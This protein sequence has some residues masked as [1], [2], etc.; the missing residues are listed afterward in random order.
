MGI[1]ASE[2]GCESSGHPKDRE[3][4]NW[5]DLEGFPQGGC[6][7]GKWWQQVNVIDGWIEGS[8]RTEKERKLMGSVESEHGDG[9]V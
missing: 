8:V 5:N 3:L 6:R 1:E 7:M 4:V 9:G 2:V